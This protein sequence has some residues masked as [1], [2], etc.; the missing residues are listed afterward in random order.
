[1]FKSFRTCICSNSRSLC[2]SHNFLVFVVVVN[3]NW[4]LW[5][6]AV[7][8]GD[9]SESNENEETKKKN[10]CF[11][12]TYWRTK[13]IHSI[14]YIRNRIRCACVHIAQW[15]LTVVGSVLF[16]CIW[17]NFTIWHNL[18]LTIHYTVSIVFCDVR[19]FHFLFS[20]LLYFVHIIPLDG[21][22]HSF[23]HVSCCVCM[24]AFANFSS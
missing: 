17:V 14:R 6:L 20:W 21:I 16:Y 4:F 3:S 11:L 23:I 18:S 8:F 2:R 9:D 24:F 5:L 7:I 10:T 1:M 12:C 22:F 15:R 13:H 19:V